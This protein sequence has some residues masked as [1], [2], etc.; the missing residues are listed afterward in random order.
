MLR[1]VDCVTSQTGLSRLT[2]MFSEGTWINL[3]WPQ[4]STPSHTA[5]KL[6]LVVT[7]VSST[8]P[9]SDPIQ[10][11]TGET[12]QLPELQNLNIPQNNLHLTSLIT[13]IQ[14]TS[15]GNLADNS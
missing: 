1:I 6:S 15:Q 13:G 3:Q 2:C 10:I 5:V 7:M 4:R 12:L 8:P 11:C 14:T 9:L